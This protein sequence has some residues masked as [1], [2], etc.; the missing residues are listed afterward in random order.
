[1]AWMS[2]RCSLA[3][4][5]QASRSTQPAI[6]TENHETRDSMFLKVTIATALADRLNLE[7]API[8]TNVMD[9]SENPTEI[10]DEYRIQE[11]SLVNRLTRERRYLHTGWRLK[12]D[13]LVL[14][15]DINVYVDAESRRAEELSDYNERLEQLYSIDNSSATAIVSL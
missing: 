11:S 6:T 13:T 8:D 2:R 15:P 12:S 10:W 7:D 3:W 1:L 4:L 9:D 14:L 5:C